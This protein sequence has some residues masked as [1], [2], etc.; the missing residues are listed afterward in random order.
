MEFMDTHYD[1]IIE[2]EDTA[3]NEIANEII[4]GLQWY[5]HPSNEISVDYYKSMIKSLIN[6]RGK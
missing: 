1:I 6:L 2:D 4:T 3:P 5:H